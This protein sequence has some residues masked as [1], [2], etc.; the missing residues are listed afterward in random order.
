MEGGR[1]EGRRE[2]ERHL[3]HKGTRLDWNYSLISRTQNSSFYTEYL[4]RSHPFYLKYTAHRAL[5][6]YPITLDTR[7][8]YPLCPNSTAR[9]AAADNRASSASLS[10]RSSN[11]PLILKKTVDRRP[12]LSD[13]AP[14]PPPPLPPPL[15]LPLPPLLPPLLK[16]SVPLPSPLPEG[17]SLGQL[18][19]KLSSLFLLGSGGRGGDVST[20]VTDPAGC[21]YGQ[22]K[23]REGMKQER[24]SVRKT[25]H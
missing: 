11:G 1:E 9:A 25:R 21:C 8:T 14:V 24:Y 19:E 15:P 2:T 13:A 7:S 3:G 20:T 18:E 5:C 16:L 17:G 23:G 6:S 10:I 12:L 4:F 22:G